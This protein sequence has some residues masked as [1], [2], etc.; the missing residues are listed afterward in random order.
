MSLTTFRRLLDRF[1]PRPAN[2]YK[3]PLLGLDGSGKTTLLYRLKTGEIVS[4]IPTIGF[5]VE[6]VQVRTGKGVI[7]M[8]CWDAGGC[9]KF[10][11]TF[12]RPYTSGSDA[13]IWVVDSNDRERLSESIEELSHHI[14]ILTSD[15]NIHVAPENLPLLIIATKQDLANPMPIDELRSKFATATR[16]SPYYILG[17]SSRTQGTAETEAFGWLLEAIETARAGKPPTSAPVAAAPNPQSAAALESKL[18]EWLVRS[19][20]DSTAEVFLQQF[21]T[22]NLPAWDHYTHIRIAYL[23]LT[24]HGRQKGKNMIFDGLQKYIAQSDQTRGKT[25][26]ITMTY[27]WIQMV[28]FGISSMPPLEIAD[29]ASDTSS[30]KTLVVE[31]SGDKRTQG[32]DE[33]PN[34][35]FARFLLLNPH[36]VDGSL[37]AEYYSKEVIM[38]PEAKAGMVLPDKKPLP[39][40]VPKAPI[41]SG[42]NPLQGSKETVSPSRAVEGRFGVEHYTYSRHSA[43]CIR[44]ESMTKCICGR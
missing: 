25:F 10:S 28:H 6:K 43:L 31:K 29:S 16:K 5:F 27:F 9:S 40:L 35:H 11:P 33:K 12:F 4:T 22:L 1:Y 21:E 32:E 38:T 8:L 30:A 24:I 3:I 7:T 2:G 39:N 18:E 36:L 23:L 26:H 37:W 42:D 17:V 14:D 15:P 19:E 13:L 44:Q 20:N 34:D 41:F